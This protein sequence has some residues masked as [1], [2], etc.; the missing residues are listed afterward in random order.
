M[1]LYLAVPRQSRQPTSTAATRPAQTREWIARLPLLNT[2]ESLQQIHDALWEVNRTEIKVTQRLKL[3]DMY[4]SPLQVIRRQVETR[5]TRGAAP[6]SDADLSLAESF[7]DCSMEMAYGYKAVIL[8]VAQHRR[9]RQLAELRLSM[10]RAMFY[11]EQT[12][13]AGALHHQAPPE[14]IWTEVH[15]IYQ[16]AAQLGIEDESIKDPIT[17]V[18]SSTSISLTYRRALLFGLSDPFHQSVPLMGRL[19]SFLRRH[20]QDAQLKGYSRPPTERCQFVIDPQSDYPARAYVKQ[21]E[22]EP[23][24]NALLLDT[25]NLT[26]SAHEQLKR[27]TSAEQ[28]DVELDDEF[29]DEL[30]RKLLAEVVY[31]WGMIPRRDEER[32]AADAEGVELMVGIDAAS[33][34]MNGGQP[35]EL[36]STD[37]A[38]DAGTAGTFR[39]HQANRQPAPSKIV[40]GYV[41]DRAGSGLRVAVQYNAAA[42]GSLRVG[43]IVSV[44]EEED[45]SWT[46]GLI[47]WMRC[48]EDTIHLGV[49]MLDRS[50]RPV[51]VKRVSK[52]REERFKEG[53]AVSTDE[54]DTRVLQLLTP[55][56]QYG[57]QRNLFVDDG[58]TLLMTRGLRLIERSDT[59]EWF[60]C[61]MINL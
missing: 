6:L 14:G 19:V 30:G 18:R 37:H 11:L 13:Y 25:V 21:S 42:V 7:R 40:P 28:F 35:I 5:L 24:H 20:A 59:V 48:V 26:R 34:C 4:R 58:R 38:A 47:R 16:Y 50:A 61:E 49:K 29:Q 15:T 44:R 39:L 33:R 55:P 45:S 2:R 23:P 53:L 46:P 54:G 12:I 43:D 31:A 60:E 57:P 8:T 41:V 22:S 32:T 27:L 9:R 51:A 56:G 3:L 36:S 1:K 10:A 17:R 52:E